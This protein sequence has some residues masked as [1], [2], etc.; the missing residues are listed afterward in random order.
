MNE[1]KKRP[2]RRVAAERRREARAVLQDFIA[3]QDF[4]SLPREIQLSILTLNPRLREC[5]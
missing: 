5:E 4:R 2:G 1:V 3:T